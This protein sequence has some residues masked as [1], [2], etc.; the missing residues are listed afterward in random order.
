MNLIQKFSNYLKMQEAARFLSYYLSAK[1]SKD[2][3]KNSPLLKKAENYLYAGL[4]KS[5]EILHVDSSNLGTRLIKSK[6]LIELGNFTEAENILKN[7]IKN[8]EFHTP[9]PF[10]LLGELYYE[11]QE[12]EFSLL[13]LKKAL[14]Y[15][16]PH[17]S[18]SQA[19]ELIL[20]VLQKQN[21]Y[22]EELKYLNLI[23]DG[24]LKKAMSPAFIR[25]CKSERDRV[26]RLLA[27]I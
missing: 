4:K 25:R 1:Y 11:K 19:A 15:P 24:K 7:I 26:L 21:N 27:E 6:L 12:T 22:N 10:V 2:I 16:I 8:K 20:L 14:D 5:N 9:Q 17:F 3:H 18:M 13:Y 23:I